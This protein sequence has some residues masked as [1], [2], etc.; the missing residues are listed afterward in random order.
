MAQFVR[1]LAD[2]APALVN[3]AVTDSKPYSAT[4]WHCAEVELIPLTLAESL[5]KNNTSPNKAY[6][7]QVLEREAP[8]LKYSLDELIRP[9]HT[10]NSLPAGLISPTAALP[11]R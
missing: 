7:V 9:D 4:F 5:K 10:L 3:A 1:N 11:C 2:K 8:T 6:Y